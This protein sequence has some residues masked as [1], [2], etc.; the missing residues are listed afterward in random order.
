MNY[1]DRQKDF[2]ILEHKGPDVYHLI[3]QS[4]QCESVIRFPFLVLQLLLIIFT[5]Q[6]F[7]CISKATM[8]H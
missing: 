2:K 5:Q 4:L 1:G 8:E 6:N 7:C 3:S